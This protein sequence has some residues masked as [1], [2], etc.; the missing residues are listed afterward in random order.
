MVRAGVG[1]WRAQVAV[2][3]LF[4]ALLVGWGVGISGT[5]LRGSVYEVTGTYVE[6]TVDRTILVRHDAV[7]ALDMQAMELM[8]FTAESAARSTR[9]GSPAAIACASSPAR[10]DALVVT[11]LEKL[12]D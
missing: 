12:T 5:L 2:A 7:R 3:A 8:V 11:R 10:P 9:R 6:R 1:R 4:L